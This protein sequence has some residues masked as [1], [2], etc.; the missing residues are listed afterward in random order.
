MN[1]VKKTDNY[2]KGM[3][4]ST[5]SIK[6]YTK[7]NQ[8]WYKSGHRITFNQTNFTREFHQS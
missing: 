4:I 7:F 2:R 3:L 8:K 1:L 5:F 6:K